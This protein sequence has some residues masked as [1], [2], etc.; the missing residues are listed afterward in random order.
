[1]QRCSGGTC[2]SRSENDAASSA[3]KDM[4]TRAVDGPL[5]NRQPGPPFGAGRIGR[6]AN[7]PPQLGQTFRRTVST[8]SAQKV[9]SNVQIRASMEEGGRSLSQY[10]QFG[11]SS[12]AMLI[13]P[14]A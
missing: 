11:L 1:R 3:E 4:C 12:K 8:Q 10:S 14:V 7:P 5:D 9:H 13:P 2:L 6:G